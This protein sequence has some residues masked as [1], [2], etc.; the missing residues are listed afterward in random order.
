MFSISRRVTH[1]TDESSRSHKFLHYDKQ[2][3]SCIAQDYVFYFLYT[4][5]SCH[6]H[7]WKQH[8][9]H[10]MQQQQQ[11]PHCESCRQA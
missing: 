9:P 5:A 7:M 8:I 4:V 10:G 6:L 1:F 2:S 11:P 3:V